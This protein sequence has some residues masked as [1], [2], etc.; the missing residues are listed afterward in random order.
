MRKTTYHP[1]GNGG[2]ERNNRSII[3]MLKNYVQQYPQSWDKSLPKIRSSNAKCHKE[4]GVSPHFLLTGRDLGLQVDQM[5]GKSSFVPSTKAIADLQDKMR[6]VYEVVTTRF[7]KRSNVIKE[8][9]DQKALTN[10]VCNV[11]DVKEFCDTK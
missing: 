8:R 9:H 11:G 10:T 7:E 6:L 5:T 4:T 1:A 2:V 3:A